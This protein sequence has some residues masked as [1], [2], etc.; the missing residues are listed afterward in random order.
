MD[1]L[2]THVA[3]LRT[4]VNL[5]SQAAVGPQLAPGSEAMRGLDQRNQQ[6]RAD[7]TDGW[8]A[9]TAV[10]FAQWLET[11]FANQIAVICTSQPEY[12]ID[13]GHM[14]TTGIVEHIKT[15]SVVLVLITPE[16]L[17]LPW[18]FYEMGAA[19]ALGK[20]FI[21]CVARGLSPRDLPAQAYE[22]QEAELSSGESLRSLVAALAHY[23]NV[24]PVVLNDC[25]AVA[26]TFA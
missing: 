7:R 26:Q 18:I 1:Y 2:S 12:H 21:P 20:V 5:K 3:I 23:L 17:G 6:S 8:T 15:S 9:K 22:F 4:V 11:I 10:A 19:H 16:S 14:V 25:Q 13:S 24:A